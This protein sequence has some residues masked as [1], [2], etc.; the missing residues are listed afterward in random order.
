MKLSDAERVMVTTFAD[1]ARTATAEW[2]V[3]LDDDTVGF[4]TPDITVWPARLAGSDVVSVQA[5]DDRGRVMIEEPV[6]EGRAHI[7][8]EGPEFE[9][10]RD[11]TKAKYRIGTAFAGV[12]DKVKELR[13]P[14]TPEGAVVLHIVA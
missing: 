7:V 10:L 3:Q 14:D 4:W 11:R 13:G 1:G 8:T 6:L 9:A 2:V 12:V 5:A